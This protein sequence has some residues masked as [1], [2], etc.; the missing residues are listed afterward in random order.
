MRLRLTAC[1]ARLT[2]EQI[3]DLKTDFE[4]LNVISF[5]I[6]SRTNKLLLTSDDSYRALTS[7]LDEFSQVISDLEERI[8][9]IDNS[10][11]NERLERKLDNIQSMVT[12]SAN[13]DSVMREVM[14]YLGE[15]IDGTSGKIDD[16]QEAVSDV[17]SISKIIGQVRELLPE[18]EEL[19]T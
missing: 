18:R 19:L 4:K 13:S 6:S 7:G 17:N 1:T 8:S 11:I 12:S 3:L 10:E 2:Q 14:M 16:I 5:S 15:W 9:V